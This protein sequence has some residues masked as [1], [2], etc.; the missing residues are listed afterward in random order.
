MECPYCF[1]EV[2]EAAVVCSHCGR[3]LSAFKLIAPTLEKVSGFEKRLSSL[4]EQLSSPEIRAP[5]TGPSQ[6]KQNTQE[7][8]HSV[9]ATFKELHVWFWFSALFC[10]IVPVV[11]YLL[12]TYVSAFWVSLFILMLPLAVGFEAGYFWS[13][14]HGGDY[15]VA[16]VFVGLLSAFELWVVFDAEAENPQAWTKL[17]WAAGA[18][19]LAVAALFISG[20]L[21]GDIYE[22]RTTATSTRRSAAAIAASTVVHSGGKEQSPRTTTQVQLLETMGPAAIGAIGAIITTTLSLYFTR[23]IP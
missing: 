3:D 11:A 1:E 15:V 8:K 23:T 20:V 16:G 12:L 19:G 17:D 22:A 9:E 18:S 6:A 21:F 2:K 5:D 10:A 13:G 14:R 4:E 7:H